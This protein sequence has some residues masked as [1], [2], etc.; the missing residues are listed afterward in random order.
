MLGLCFFAQ[1]F[2]SCYKQRLLSSHGVQASHCSGFSCCRAQNLEHRLS[3]HGAWTWLPC[4]MWDLPG[5]GIKPMSCALAGG[6]LT[7]G[8]PG[9]SLLSDFKTS[10]WR[11]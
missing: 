6:F 7:T 11:L 3:H 5:P 10:I 2:A 9:K 1:A 8:T 4:S